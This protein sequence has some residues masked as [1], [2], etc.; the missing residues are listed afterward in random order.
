MIRNRGEGIKEE[1]EKWRGRQVR[2]VK[3]CKKM[4]GRK[5]EIQ[6]GEK[7]GVGEEDEDRW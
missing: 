1:K 4:M 2:R 5:Y 3:R 7:E 6:M